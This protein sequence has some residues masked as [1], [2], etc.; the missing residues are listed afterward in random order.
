MIRKGEVPTAGD[1]VVVRGMLQDRPTRVRGDPAAGVVVGASV[2]VVASSSNPL[3][4]VGNAMR[5][6]VAGSLEED[7]DPR[8]ALMS[9]FLIGDTAGLAGDDVEALR[10]AGLSHF[11]AVSGS[12]VAL[13]LAAWWV[14]TAPLALSARVRSLTGLVGLALFVIITRWEPSVVRAATMAGL[15]LGGRA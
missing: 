10:R 9:G 4:T 5:R 13:F 14:L 1:H 3:F 15:V 6:R 2:E 8:A 7:S 11:V 12:N